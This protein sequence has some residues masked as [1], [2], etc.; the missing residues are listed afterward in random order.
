VSGHAGTA[1][2]ELSPIPYRGGTA[3]R[4]A[5]NRNARASRRGPS[6]IVALVAMFAFVASLVAACGSDGNDAAAT[7]DKYLRA[8]DRRD[9][10]A[11]AKLVAQP[12][13]DFADF[14]RGLVESLDLAREEHHAGDVRDE[15]DRAEVAITN[16]YTTE[17]FGAWESRGKLELT[18]RDGEWLIT[19]SPQQIDERLVSGTR[20]ALSVDWPDRA[21]VLGAGGALLTAPTPMVRVGIQG[22]RVTDPAALTGALVQAGASNTKIDGA[23]ATAR[24]HPDWFVPVME[25]TPTRYQELRPVI[26]PVPGTVFQNFTTRQA[27]SAELGTHIV[28]ST[29]AI[30]AELLQQLGPPYGP[31]DIVGRSGV[32]AEY[33]RT[34]AGKPG[35]T[36]AIVD[37]A[38]NRI[39]TL[40][41]FPQ[42]AGT[43]VQLSL[44]PAVQR[45]AEQALQS[46]GGEAAIV[47][48]RASTGEILGSASTP[49]DR[50][51]DLAL[52]G[53]L[54]PGSTFK[55]VTTADLLQHG[56]TPASGLSCPQTIT[57]DGQRFRNFEGEAVASLTLAQAFSL[58]CNA[59]F[60][61]AATDL[62][63]DT[64]ATT[65]AQF[66]IGTKPEIGLDAFGGS[67]P[68]PTNASEQAATSIGQAKVV[69]SPLTM[70]SVAATVASGTWHA[71]RLVTGAANDRV[72]PRPLDPGVA[73]AL[74]SMMEGVVTSGT[75]AGAGL[76]P[77]T[78]GKTGTAE[79]GAGSP[80]AT[81]AW[82]VGARGDVAFAI[83]VYG[84]GVG[85]AVAAPVAARFL[86]GFPS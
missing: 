40:V 58:S 79:F 17:P 80:P 51:F 49:A 59:A 38:G 28:G 78:I 73:A 22:S 34:L 26:Y 84:G 76:P 19:W 67:V 46:V 21:P 11:M 35:A 71:P 62:P 6:R 27:V 32:E 10:Q 57:V 12:P 52:R 48:V 70:A 82:F 72:E 64:F 18:R 68:T 43:P 44:D 54:P 65:A 14:H 25:L 23:L 50:P 20:L 13:A 45:A 63:A 7:V 74:R 41:S 5:P 3:S 30:T 66:G 60:I 2:S 42:E 31:N 4:G 85:G 29:G 56:L 9:Y 16:Q 81:H 47:A 69:V 53:Q 39:A 33:E 36:I 83:V 37:E 61:G 75:A 86:A 8:W 77:G 15:G 55:I 24:D 1:C